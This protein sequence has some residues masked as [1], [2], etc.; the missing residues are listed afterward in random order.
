MTNFEDAIHFTLQNTISMT[1]MAW[2]FRWTAFLPS[3]ENSI[4]WVMGIILS[5]SAIA[6]NAVRGYYFLKDRREKRKHKDD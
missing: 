6:Y 4:P 2:I 1:G 3:A 5:T